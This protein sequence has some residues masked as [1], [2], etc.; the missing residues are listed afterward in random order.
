MAGVTPLRDERS[1]D[2]QHGRMVPVLTLALRMLG[3]RAILWAVTL[4]AGA[5]WVVTVLHPEPW[6]IVTAVGYSLT[7]LLPFLW[8]GRRGGE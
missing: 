3:E 4:G 7:V 6:R 1:V 5:V 2:E 8:T